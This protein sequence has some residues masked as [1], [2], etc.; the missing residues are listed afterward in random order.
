MLPLDFSR[1]V[2]KRERAP[3]A[4]HNLELVGLADKAD[5]LPVRA[6]GRPAAARRDRARAGR[7]PAAADRRRAD[8]QPGHAHGGRDVRAAAAAQRRGLDRPLRHPRPRARRARHTGPSRSATASSRREEADMTAVVRKSFTDLTRRKARAFFTVLTLAL[9]VA[10][11][12]IFAVPRSCSRRW[13]ARSPRTGCPDVTVSMKPLR[14]SA[15]QLAALGRL[16]NVAAVEPRSLFATRV[17]VGERRERAIVIGVPDYARQRADVVTVDSGAAPGAGAVLTDQQQRGR[18]RASTR[19]AGGA[20]RVIAADGTV[21]SL[22]ISGVGRNLTGGE[23]DPTNDWITFYATP[24]TVA[25]LSGTPGYT[26]LGLPPARRQPAGGRAHRRRRPRPAA[27]DDRVHRVRRPARSSTS[28]A[29][30]RARTTSR[31]SRASSTSSR[32]WRCCRRSCSSR[33]R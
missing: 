10:S 31:A 13:S 9:A 3:L 16:P 18:A 21:R 1:R 15:A 22:P 5:N 12:G 11:V 26:S 8:R 14:L 30:T 19:D 29:A 20:A 4:M 7:R 23:D 2:P 27:R 33:T 6:V 25:A 28:P 17:W 24:Q 32:C